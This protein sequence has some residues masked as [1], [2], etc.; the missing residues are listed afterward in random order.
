MLL[1]VLLFVVLLVLGY[2]RQSRLSRDRANLRISRDRANLDLQMIS[3]Q[4]KIRVETQADDSASL[5]SRKSTGASLPPGP[6]SSSAGQSVAEQEISRSS[7]ADSGVVPMA[8][9]PLAAPT[10]WPSPSL[11]GAN[12]S[13]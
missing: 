6:P 11:R 3:H 10:V 8:P 7:T 2:R 13:A 9:D 12:L 5:P 4:V 1:V